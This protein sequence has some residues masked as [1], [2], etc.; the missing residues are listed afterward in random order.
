MAMRA[1]EK[2]E[3][4]LIGIFVLLMASYFALLLPVN[5]KLGSLLLYCSALLLLQ[6]LIR[7]LYHYFP[8][9]PLDGSSVKY[10]QCICLES[11]IGVIGLLAGFIVTFSSIDFQLSLSPQ[12]W[13][14]LLSVVLIIGFLLKDWVFHWQPIGLR[15]EKNHMNVIFVFKK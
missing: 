6:G 4:L 2:C 9:N 5:I 12:V 14:L 11:S 13:T 8:Q 7:D 1:S 15:R 3:V 10:A